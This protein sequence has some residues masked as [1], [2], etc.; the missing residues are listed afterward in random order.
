ME[1]SL[2][3][4]E[5]RALLKYAL[6]H[7]SCNCPAERDLETCLLIVRLCEKAGIKAPPCVEEM[8]GF[9]I[10]EFQRKIRDIEQRHRKPIAEVLSEFE[11]EGTITLQ[12]E[13]DR[14]EGSFAVKMLDV[15]S[16]EKKTLEEKRER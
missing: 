6:A 14:I 10:E 16:K 2:K 13:V 8:G 15:L 12:D 5:L 7:C 4:E 9:G 1:I 11:K 3:I